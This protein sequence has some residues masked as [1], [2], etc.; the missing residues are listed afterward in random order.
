MKKTVRHFTIEALTDFNYIS[1]SNSNFESL[2]ENESNSD[3]KNES[4]YET[5]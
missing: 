4:N 2:F 5:E 1:D 3:L